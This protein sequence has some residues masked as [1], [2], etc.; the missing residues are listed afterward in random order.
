MRYTLPTQHLLYFGIQAKKGK[1]DASGVTKAGNANVAEIHNQALMMWRTKSSIP[2]SISGPGGSRFH[3]RRWR[4]HQGRPNW[5]G[6]AL[7][8]SKRSQIMF[9]DRMT[10]LI[11]TS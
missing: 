3:C 1:I 9:I 5:I 10:F 2:R 4:D 8:D 11:C 7:D 6:N